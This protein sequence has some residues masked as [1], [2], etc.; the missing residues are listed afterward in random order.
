GKAEALSTAVELLASVGIPDAQ[1]RGRDYPHQ[2][3]GGMQQRVM[4]AMALACNPSLIIAAEPTTALDVTIQAQILDLLRDIR[5]RDNHGFGMLFITHNLGVVAEIADRVLVMYCGRIVEEGTV[6]DV[7]RNPNH[8]YTKGL[9]ASMPRVDHDTG[10]RQPL[11]AIPGTVPP[12]DEL[13]PGCSFAPR[14]S[15]AI[16]MCGDAL[17]GLADVAPGHR[18]RCLRWQ[19]MGS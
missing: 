8:P 12:L 17:P 14:C 3:S 1:K 6:G 15:Y 19:E 2:M 4:I 16:D 13:P 7:F 5:H 18:S 11:Y 9:I 10:E